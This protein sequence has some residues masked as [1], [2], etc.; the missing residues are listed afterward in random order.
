MIKS[1]KIQIF[2]KIGN[3]FGLTIWLNYVCFEINQMVKLSG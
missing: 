1:A 3:Q 2:R